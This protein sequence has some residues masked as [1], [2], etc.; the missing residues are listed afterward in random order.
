M[1]GIRTQARSKVRLNVIRLL[2][3]GMLLIFPATSEAQENPPI[4]EQ[5]AKTYGLDFVSPRHGGRKALFDFD[6]G[7][8]GQADGIRKLDQRAITV[9]R[10]VRAADNEG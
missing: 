4:A 7:F 1:T 5:I 6:F 9:G 10:F 2:A 8:I 3:F